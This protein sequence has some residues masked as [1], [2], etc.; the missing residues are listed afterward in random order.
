M[1][2]V[3]PHIH[4]VFRF[5]KNCV[6]DNPKRLFSALIKY[7]STYLIGKEDDLTCSI[8]VFPV[9]GVSASSAADLLKCKTNRVCY[10]RK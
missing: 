5:G 7:V 8:K 10:F 3:N 4:T 9:N 6:Y 1:I 2:S